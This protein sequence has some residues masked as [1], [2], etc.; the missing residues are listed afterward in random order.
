MRRLT[1]AHRNYERMLVHMVDGRNEAW[2]RENVA[3]ART[4]ELEFYVE[5]LEEHNT[6]LQEEEV[7]YEMSE[8][9]TANNDDYLYQCHLS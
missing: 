1:T 5:D 8:Y 4:H 7:V 2:H 9:Q 3:R 6:Y